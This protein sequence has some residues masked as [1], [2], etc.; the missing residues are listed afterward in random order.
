MSQ[1]KAQLI[2]S[3]IDLNG[4]ELTFPTTQGSAFQSLRNGSTAGTL[5]FGASVLQIVSNYTARASSD[6][7]TVSK[8]AS[9]T[10]VPAKYGLG[11][12]NR[13]YADIETLTIT[14]KSSTSTLVL[15]G[16]TGPDAITRSNRGAEGI[17][18]VKDE[19][20]GYGFGTYP[21]YD[22]SNLRPQ[23]SPE[24]GLTVAVTSGGTSAQTW[25]LKAF[26][27]NEA[28]GSTTNIYRVRN[29]SFIIMEIAS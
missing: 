22:V 12:D 20:T 7:I 6:M 8:T 17:V 18:F 16:T 24:Y 29:S 25:D 15:M 5:E 27:Y 14:P 23:Y 9:S 4:A 21:G 28:A 3:P 11:Q 19:T 2:A 26:S 13:E 1:T 10:T